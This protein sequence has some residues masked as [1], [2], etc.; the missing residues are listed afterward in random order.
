M[1]DK[2]LVKS[3]F[4]TNFKT[5]NDNAIVQKKV[6]E[7]LTKLVPFKKYGKILEI[8]CGTGFLTEKLDYLNAKKL[9]LNDIC[10]EVSRII[11]LKNLE[12]AFIIGDAE[13]VDFPSNLDLIISANTIQWLTNI[14]TFFEK[15]AQ[16]LNSD[17]KLIFSTF[18][19][20]NYTEITKI[21]GSSLEYKTVNE[22][23]NS[24]KKHF[25]VQTTTEDTITVYFSTLKEILSHIKNTGVNA[26][27]TN[28]LTKSALTKAEK[29]YEKLR[30][31][32]GLPLT[33]EPAY[34][35]LKKR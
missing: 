30:T 15:S 31:E 3:R 33:Y 8:G 12:Y 34:F 9:F 6:V 26:L 7:N 28:K 10:P 1:I 27:S 29:E 4:G 11:K 35:V 14:E 23:T 22:I 16:A 19:K 25:Y 32:K 13:E 5:Y 17:G 20:G 21:F 2:N 24:A 18:V